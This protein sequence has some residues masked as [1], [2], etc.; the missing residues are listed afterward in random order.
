MT[1][2]VF[3]LA[4]YASAGLVARPSLEDSVSAPRATFDIECLD[5]EGQVKWVERIEN[6][7]FTAG[8]LD[9]L[10]VYFGATSKPAAWYLLLKSTAAG[11]AAA[12]TLA[13]HAGWT[14]ITNL[15]AAANRP[16]I[17]FTAA[18]T[19]STVNGQIQ[20]TAT[21]GTLSG[22]GT[23]TGCGVT[24]TQAK[25]TTTGVL[26]NAGDFSASRTVASGDTL[27]VT[28]TLTIT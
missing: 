22:G 7:V 11:E 4:D 27:N 15:Y 28:V 2:D 1:N 26:Y 6:M 18:T 25:A 10:N 20:G 19:V 17:T 13:T 8:K 14:E 24:Q 12:D 3:A 21:T 5:G 23:V 9:L 16:T